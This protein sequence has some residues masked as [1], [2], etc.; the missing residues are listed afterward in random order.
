[1]ILDELDK[2]DDAPERDKC[3]FY[4]CKSMDD[5]ETHQSELT[6]AWFK[7]ILELYPDI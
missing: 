5:H 4:L 2:I 6:Q 1:M 7:L 3:L